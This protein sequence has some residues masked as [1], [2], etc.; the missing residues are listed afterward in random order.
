[1]RKVLILCICAL[2]LAACYDNK[3]K[4]SEAGLP[5]GR[6]LLGSD[7]EEVFVDVE[8]AQTDGH[9]Q[10]G[11]MNRD[12]L[13]DDAGMMFVYFE[14]ASGGFWM[15]DVTIRLSIA[16][17]GE[18]QTILKIMNMEPCTK[19]PCRSYVPGVEYTAALEVNQGAFE[20]WGIEVGDTVTLL[21]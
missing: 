20:E 21:R 7:D 3:P 16:F 18:D 14:P 4:V 11:L 9:R 10:Q 1:M 19:D 8:I 15:K 2:F 5:I 13:P 12:S 6:V 17:I